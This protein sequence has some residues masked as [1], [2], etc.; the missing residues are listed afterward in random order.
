[1][2]R[3]C[4]VGA[5]N[6][7]EAL[8]KGLLSSGYRRKDLCF[9]EISD[10][11]REFV[12]KKYRIED[13]KGLDEALEVSKYFVIA[14]KPQDGRSLLEKISPRWKKN[15]VLISVMAGVSISRI[16]SYLRKDGKIVRVM[17]NIC[18]GLRQGVIG[19]VKNEQVE[20]H[21]YQFILDLFSRLGL[22]IEMKEQLFDALTAYSGSGPAFF[23][24]FLEGMID[25]GV[26]IGFSRD[27]S[28]LMAYK[29][30]QGTLT[31]LIEEKVHPTVL[32]EKITSPSGTT[33]YGLSSLEK[34]GF[35]G[36]IIE[37]FEISKERAREL[38]S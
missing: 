26:K 27:L 38:S 17:P 20:E 16:S 35:R 32:K 23:L 15:N 3:V 31:L 30:V 25:A 29:V 8:I 4:I 11:R 1:M 19:I 13:L 21:E 33:I 37:A 10:S 6:M 28:S 7:G 5:G 9:L 34:K 2:E 36:A 18:V 14:V 22:V 12:R 24:S